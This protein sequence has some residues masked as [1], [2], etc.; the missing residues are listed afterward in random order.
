MTLQNLKELHKTM[1]TIGEEVMQKFPQ[2][3][4]W[5]KHLAK[6]GTLLHLG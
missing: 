3:L 5:M 2:I 4:K 1:S 6:A